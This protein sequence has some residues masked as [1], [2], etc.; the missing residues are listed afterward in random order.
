RRAGDA[1]RTRGGQARRRVGG[2][3][4][5]LLRPRGGRHGGAGSAARDRR[6]ARAGAVSR[7]SGRR[8]ARAA[9][10]PLCVRSQRPAVAERRLVAYP[11]DGGRVTC[12][13]PAAARPTPPRRP[14]HTRTPITLRSRR[15][16]RIPTPII[17]TI[18]RTRAG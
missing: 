13:P 4:A 14:T 1:R 5:V 12:V 10:R 17:I 6:D 9:L 15:P 2:R 11:R 8:H 18:T 7:V 16:T 3:A